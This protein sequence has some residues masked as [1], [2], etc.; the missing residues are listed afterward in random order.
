MNKNQK[1]ANNSDIEKK[2]LEELALIKESLKK[3]IAQRKYLEAKIKL[4]ESKPKKNQ[5]SKLKNEDIFRSMIQNSTDIVTLIDKTGAICYASHSIKDILGYT[6]NELLNRT[7]FEFIHPDDYH[8]V[9]S[10]FEY[11]LN[12]IGKGRKIE[13][14][15]LKKEGSYIE[16]EAQGNNQCNNPSIQGIIINVRDI[17]QRKKAE[18]ELKNSEEQKDAIL[19]SITD[20]FIALDKNW[21]LTYINKRANV[22]FNRSNKNLIGKSFWETFTD[23]NEDNQKYRNAVNKVKHTEFEYFCLRVQKWLNVKIFPSKNGVSIFYNDITESKIQRTI[24]EVEQFSLIENNRRTKRL[25]EIIDDAILKME[26]II[27]GMFC[28]VLIVT[29]NGKSLTNFSGPSISKNYQAAIDGIEIAIGSDAGAITIFSDKNNITPNIQKDPNWRIFKEIAKKE[30]FVSCWSFP[31]TSSQGII[32][33]SFVVY[34]KKEMIPS[35]NDLIFISKIMGILSNLIER[36]KKEDEITK[37]SLIAKNTNKAVFIA[38]LNQKITWI[39]SAFTDMTGYQFEE[40]IGENPF[41]LL[42][43]EKSD[44][45][46]M[47]Y[48]N[49][50]MAG[51]NSFTL[52]TIFHKKNKDIYWSRITG[53]PMYDETG[54]INQYFAI[55]EDTTARKLSKIDLQDSE[56][57]YRALFHSNSQPMYIYDKATLKFIEVN[58]SAVNTY[59]YST[60]E[61]NEMKTTDLLENHA[62]ATYDPSKEKINYRNNILNST[63]ILKDLSINKTKSGKLINVEIIRNEMIISGKASILVIVNDVTK[64]LITERKLI[65]SNERFSLASKAVN[66]AIWDFNLNTNKLFWADGISVLFGYEEI[67]ELPT[68]ENWKSYVHPD[69][70][71]SVKLNFDSTLA[72]KK[73]DYW[74]S[75]YRFLKKD[76]N[77]SYVLDNAYIVRN[78]KGTPTRVIGAMQ[79]ITK[80]KNFENQKLTLISETQDHERKR[81]S[82]ELHD[83]L[84][85]HL[86]ALNLYLSQIA[87]EEMVDHAALNSC[88]SVLKTSMNQTR[89]L[90]YSLT[91]PELD[92]G[93]LLALQAMFERLKAV[94]AFD[95]F[96]QISPEIEDVDF[97]SVDKYNL[98]RIIQE[99][100][101]NSIKHSGGSL[102][103]CKV[104]KIKK[105]IYID[106][107]DN[108]KGFDITKK[109]N[110]LGLKNIEQRAYL[111]KIKYTLKSTIGKGTQMKIELK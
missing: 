25:N 68:A 14:R 33:A 62:K 78:E 82:M 29:E 67:E 108:G 1:N 88:F 15:F 27:P 87:E 19:S 66:E 11:A 39:N 80:Q 40:V 24:L 8:F 12:H 90:C 23:I 47:S 21:N 42:T 61:F 16:I 6:E 111:A 31:I 92:H 30:G 79:D 59:G 26:S 102:I 37:L 56:K 3:E 45:D 83:G 60:E 50:Q 41:D 106:T 54:N 2:L 28:S 99:F 64:K 91:P 18:E 10:E 63:E 44:P 96:L 95:V 73:L 110:S 20:A 43:G 86:V 4:S 109:S 107:N 75:E 81:F 84:A 94:K 100:V 53:Q 58:E 101:N 76:G 46:I 57:R 22:L 77:Y 5:D 97:Q 32:L 103:S 72:N 93:F 65:Q 35:K 17:T 51:N 104:T 69:D 70:Y 89:A 9:Q 98:Y 48:L 71:P 105:V 13:C 7:I 52:N 55:Q 49:Q 74:N 34:F 36:R 85:Q 38:D